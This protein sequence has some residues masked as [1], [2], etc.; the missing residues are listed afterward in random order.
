[1]E[2]TK[3]KTYIVY[4]GDDIPYEPTYPIASFLDRNKAEEFLEKSLWRC[5]GMWQFN[6]IWRGKDL[7][8]CKDLWRGNNQRQ[9]NS[10]K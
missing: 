8:K 9:C 3:K 1:M 2:L 10:F 7:W 6:D 5:K 4:G